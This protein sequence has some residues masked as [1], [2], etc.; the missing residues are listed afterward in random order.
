[1]TR[2][3]AFVGCA[4]AFAAAA[5]ADPKAAVMQA[6]RDWASAIV[7]GDVALLEKVLAPE[8]V[9]THSDGRRDSKESYITSIKTGTQKYGSFQHGEMQVKLVGKTLALLN[10][11]AKVS[12]A[13]LGR[14]FSDLNMVIL[15][16][17][18]LRDGR[19]Q[20][21]AHQSARKPAAQ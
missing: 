15:H 7:K 21:V 18:I 17:Y 2:R 11:E 19:W 8:L 16:V 3:T 14:N 9:Y 20:M 6:E 12:A 10:T 5:A 4:A 1:M 13:S